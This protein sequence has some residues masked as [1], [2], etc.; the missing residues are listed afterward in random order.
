MIKQF[1]MKTKTQN[2]IFNS[3]LFSLLFVGVSY[4]QQG[5][6]EGREGGKEPPSVDE[7]FKHMD[8]D[9]DGVLSKKEVRGPLKDMFDE[10]DTNEDGFLS[11][12]EVEK[13]PKPK[14]R[15]PKRQ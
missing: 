12:E 4:A 1:I 6:G 5:G 3:L 15:R 2:S 9:E 13:A 14:G 11:K 8:E 7:I 10:I